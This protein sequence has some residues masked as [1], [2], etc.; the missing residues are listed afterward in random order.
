M[1]KEVHDKEKTSFLIFSIR[2]LACCSFCIISI[3]TKRCLV[4]TPEPTKVQA[5]AYKALSMASLVHR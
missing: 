5:T 2:L 1:E 4:R 3:T